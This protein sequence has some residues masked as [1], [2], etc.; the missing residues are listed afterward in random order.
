M[1]YP[2]EIKQGLIDA[3]WQMLDSLFTEFMLFKRHEL[4]H[5]G[6]YMQYL[7]QDAS[8]DPRFEA[9]GFG[10][11]HEKFHMVYTSPE[12][13][14]YRDFHAVA[15]FL[16]LPTVG[17]KEVCTTS[18]EWT[19]QST[20]LGA[21]AHKVIFRWWDCITGFQWWLRWRAQQARGYTDKTLHLNT[22]YE[23]NRVRDF[24]DTLSII[25][26]LYPQKDSAL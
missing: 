16:G 22:G 25:N 19:T 24:P 11:H 18:G 21:G 9:I 5:T 2:T 1:S 13:L 12:G 15:A 20:R 23:I 3:H 14:V 7:V 8:R 6:F 26:E 17:E 4:A 10:R